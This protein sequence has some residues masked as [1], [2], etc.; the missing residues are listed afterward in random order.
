M[1]EATARGAGTRYGPERRDLTISIN[2]VH[3]AIADV[4]VTGDVYVD[5]VQLVRVDGHWRIIN[6]LW[7]PAH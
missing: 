1:I 2:H 3:G 4:R 5:Y 7:A 6:A